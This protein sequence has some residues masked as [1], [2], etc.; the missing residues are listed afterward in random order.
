MATN[1]SIVLQLPEV[2]AGGPEQSH[3]QRPAGDEDHTGGGAQL[4]G[5]L[6]P[7]GAGGRAAD[8]VHRPTV[9]GCRQDKRFCGHPDRWLHWRRVPDHEYHPGVPGCAPAT[10]P[11]PDSGHPGVCPAT[12]LCVPGPEVAQ[13]VGGSCG[14]SDY[15]HQGDAHS[16]GGQP[17]GDHSE[18][19]TF[20]ERILFTNYRSSLSP[21]CAPC[22]P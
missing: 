15:L 5:V 22:P 18:F 3:L 14:L 16:P 19:V 8:Q 11:A 13:P 21:R 12:G 17:P 1:L 4:Q 2:P 10:G 20:L 7:Q 9:P 6:H